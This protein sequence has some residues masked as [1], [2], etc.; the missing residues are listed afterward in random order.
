MFPSILDPLA[1][2][3]NHKELPRG[4]LHTAC[5][6]VCQEN[7][8]LS[9]DQKAQLRCACFFVWTKSAAG[10]SWTCRRHQVEY[11]FSTDNLCKDAL[12]SGF[13]FHERLCSQGS[14]PARTH[15][16][17]WLGSFRPDPHLSTGHLGEIDALVFLAGFEY[18]LALAR[19]A[20]F[21]SSASQARSSWRQWRSCDVMMLR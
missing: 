19:L 11:Y 12:I 6:L 4:F 17:G 1:A 3:V 13:W 14:F 21:Q 9:D 10:S 20:R 15:G 8:E 5:C 18:V 7:E 2:A 16:A